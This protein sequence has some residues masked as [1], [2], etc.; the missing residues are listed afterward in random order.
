MRMQTVWVIVAAA[1]ATAA[2]LWSVGQWRWQ[3]DSQAMLTALDAAA[4]GSIASTSADARART[5]G[6]QTSM[7]PWLVRLWAYE[8]RSGMRVPAKGEVSWLLP[9]G[10]Y[11]YWRGHLGGIHCEWAQ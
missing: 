9:S 3:H 11:A 4:D 1:L 8:D 2:A 5:V 6:G 10:P 7:A